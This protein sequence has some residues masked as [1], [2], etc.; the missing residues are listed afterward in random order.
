MYN[1]TD[2]PTPFEFENDDMKNSETSFNTVTI[3]DFYSQLL[4]PKTSV[5]RV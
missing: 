5:I 4:S 1:G 3:T 2:N